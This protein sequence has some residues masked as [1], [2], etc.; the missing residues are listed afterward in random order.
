MDLGSRGLAEQHKGLGSTPNTEKR[1]NTIKKSV[2]MFLVANAFTPEIRKLSHVD[3]CE[4]QDNQ[5]CKD[6]PESKRRKEERKEKTVK[7]SQYYAFHIQLYNL[8]LK[9]TCKNSWLQ[10][11][12]LSLIGVQSP[13]WS[14]K[15]R[16]HFSFLGTQSSLT[17]PRNRLFCTCW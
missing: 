8:L 16:I 17:Y 7:R 2:K 15:N 6:S 13:S 14:C 5:N 1:K 9:T 10:S 11:K 3:H 4:F 12:K